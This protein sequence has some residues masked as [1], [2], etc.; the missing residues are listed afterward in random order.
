MWVIV[1][2]SQCCIGSVYWTSGVPGLADSLKLEVYQAWHPPLNFSVQES[3]GIRRWCTAAY[4][5]C[6][7]IM[8]FRCYGLLDTTVRMLACMSSMIEIY[9]ACAYV[10]PFE[11]L[12]AETSFVGA[13]CWSF[14]AVLVLSRRHFD[15]RTHPVCSI[16]CADETALFSR[17]TSR[18]RDMFNVDESVIGV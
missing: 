15:T 18:K 10:L 8:H 6:A 2:A 5:A 17:E 16:L 1:A 7:G 14:G 9:C 12:Y 3:N 13:W 4:C 11:C